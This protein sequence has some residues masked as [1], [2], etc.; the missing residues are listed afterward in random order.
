MSAL[1]GTMSVLVALGAAI[2]L[3]IQGWRAA[4]RPDGP[5]TIR[6]RTPVLVLLVAAVASLLVL[7]AALLGDDFSLEYVANHHAAATPLPV[8]RG[9]RL[10]RARR[11]HR[12][13]GRGA[14]GRHLAG[15]EGVSPRA[16]TGSAPGRWR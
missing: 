12:P 7:E 16:R 5:V 9:Q 4:A 1:L 6:L 2:A 8:H 10:G 15:V 13:L 14:G 11:E 3:A